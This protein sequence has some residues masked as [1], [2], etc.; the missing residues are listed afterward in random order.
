MYRC[1]KGQ[2]N[3]TFSEILRVILKEF[4]DFETEQNGTQIF[5]MLSDL[6]LIIAQ[7]NPSLSLSTDKMKVNIF[8]AQDGAW[9]SD[10]NIES[11]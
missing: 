6:F 8:R 3:F 4:H 5:M 11:I 2:R 1:L 7:P 9:F 10:L